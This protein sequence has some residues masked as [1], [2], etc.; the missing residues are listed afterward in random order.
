MYEI[1]RIISTGTRLV[2]DVLVLFHRFLSIVLIQ[3][4]L[5]SDEF[6][7]GLLRFELQHVDAVL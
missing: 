2:G 4:L 6:V 3:G 1:Q 5:G 7:A